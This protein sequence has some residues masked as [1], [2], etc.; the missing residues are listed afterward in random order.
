MKI[1]ILGAAAGLGSQ[2]TQQA[3][4]KGHQV[5]ALSLNPENIPLHPNL[6]VIKGSATSNTDVAR[7]IAGTDAVLITI[8]TKQK[9]GTTL[10]SEM[11]KAVV[12]AAE[13]LSYSNPVIVVSGFGVG[14]SSRYLSLYMKVVINLF[15]KDQYNDKG[16]MEHIF[17]QS[18]LAWEIIRPGILTNTPSDTSYNLYTSLFKGMKVGRIAR[19]DVAHYMLAEA[20]AP[21]HLKSRVAITY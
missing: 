18:T 10:F 8:G 14:E 5:T 16:R 17:A 1:A 4:L 15:L 21:K 12:S 2:A 19:A 7:A 3:L 20:Q 11:A 9:K 6:N 13:S